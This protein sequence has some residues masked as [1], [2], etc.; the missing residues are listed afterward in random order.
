LHGDLGALSQVFHDIDVGVN[1]VISLGGWQAELGKL[2]KADV[3]LGDVSTVFN[4]PQGDLLV[5]GTAGGFNPL[6][7]TPFKNF[8]I[9]NN[10][11]FQMA[12]YG[13]A[14]DRATPSSAPRPP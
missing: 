11:V 3:Q 4:G 10:D 14:R 1:G 2:L 6:A 12:L 5:N 13:D 7:G 9:T 8:V